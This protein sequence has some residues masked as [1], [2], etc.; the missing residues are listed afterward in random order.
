MPTTDK[1]IKEAVDSYHERVD[2]LYNDVR[3]WIIEHCANA[4]FQQT[5]IELSEE[6]TARR[7]HRRR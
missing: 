1:N 6:L 5:Q 4:V 7:E 3:P 2:K